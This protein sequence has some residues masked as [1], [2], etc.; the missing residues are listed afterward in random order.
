MEVSANTS[1][2]KF[3]SLLDN[4]SNA[5]KSDPTSNQGKNEHSLSSRP[6]KRSRL[7]QAPLRKD[8]ARSSL[9]GLKH[10]LVTERTTRR[11]DGDNVQ[12]DKP[13]TSAGAYTP[14]SRDAFLYRL[15][16]FA[17]PHLWS[18]KPEAINELQWAKRGWICEDKETVACKGLCG[19]RLVIDLGLSQFGDEEVQDTDKDEQVHD[20]RE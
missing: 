8:N 14:W 20:I 17:D 13:V 18:P 15:R 19:R 12:H 1:K 6:V 5:A 9:A 11:N 10:N 7:R 4:I 16:T 2:R 3:Q